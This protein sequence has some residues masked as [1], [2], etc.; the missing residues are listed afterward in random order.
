M[1][2]RLSTLPVRVLTN[3]GSERS[4]RSIRSSE[5][6]W[7][8]FGSRSRFGS[9]DE[10]EPLAWRAPGG[11]ID[12]DRVDE[13]SEPRIGLRVV[14]VCEDI[15]GPGGT[16]TERGSSESNLERSC[17]G[18]MDDGRGESKARCTGVAD[19]LAGREGVKGGGMRAGLGSDVGLA[20][21]HVTGCLVDPSI[22]SPMP[23]NWRR[24]DHSSRPFLYLALALLVVL[25]VLPFLLLAFYSEE[26][27]AVRSVWPTIARDMVRAIALSSTTILHKFL[28]F[29]GYG[30]ATRVSAFARHLLSVDEANRPVIYI[31]SSAPE[32]VFAD[33]IA[34]GA[35]YRFAEIDPVIVQPLA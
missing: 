31:V 21:R 10:D 34:C 2:P 6:T 30:H 35:R 22:S 28:Y 23:Y 1:K 17:L 24:P 27:S 32:H 20:C 26:W 29:L 33:S 7:P 16:E 9:L 13:S 3:D 15:L 5:P 4:R 25:T 18:G 12:A 8:P 19:S 14:C 11:G